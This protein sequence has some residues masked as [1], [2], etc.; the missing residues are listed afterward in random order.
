MSGCLYTSPHLAAHSTSLL[1][2]IL[3][4]L[5]L[6]SVATAEVLLL[7]IT[8]LVGWCFS[9]MNLAESKKLLYEHLHTHCTCHKMYWRCSISWSYPYP[10]VCTFYMQGDI[11]TVCSERCPGSWLQTRVREDFTITEKAPSRAFSCLKAPTSGFTSKTLR[12]HYAKRALT[13]R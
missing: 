8:W 9:V 13:P 12:R 1:G 4:F 10:G 6:S 2:H 5:L 7:P 11:C 3:I